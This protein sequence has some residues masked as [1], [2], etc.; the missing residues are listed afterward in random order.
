MKEN[1]RHARAYRPSLP[2]CQG[3][4]RRD[5]FLLDRVRRTLVERRLVEELPVAR[6]AIDRLLGCGHCAVSTAF[7]MSFDSS[8]PRVLRL[9]PLYRFQLSP[10]G[11]GRFG[12]I[13]GSPFLHSTTSTGRDTDETDRE[14]SSTPFVR[15][16]HICV[17]NLGNTRYWV[18]APYCGWP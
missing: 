3:L 14:Y 2:A 1:G 6:V 13:T 10:Q 17:S 15:P 11:K 18:S 8:R 16:Q 5:A 12:L 9:G 7:T 4:L